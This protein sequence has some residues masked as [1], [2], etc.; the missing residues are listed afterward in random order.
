MQR[1]IEVEQP[2]ELT[3]HVPPRYALNLGIV[4]PLDKQKSVGT[5]HRTERLLGE[6]FQQQ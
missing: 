4:Q 6:H 3:R 1:V 5:D 2:D